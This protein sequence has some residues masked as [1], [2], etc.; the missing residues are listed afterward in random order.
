MGARRL[1][2]AGLVVLACAAVA[3]TALAAPA[4][5]GRH[6]QYFSLMNERVAVKKL[7]FGMRLLFR[8]FPGAKS[9]DSPRHGHGPV[10]FGEVERPG[11]TIFGAGRGHWICVGHEWNAE[12]GGG[13][14]SCTTRAG[15][16]ELGLLD[17]GSCGK[18]RPRHFRVNGLVPDGVTALELERSDATIGRTVPVIDNTFAFTVGREDFTLHGV[19][20]A[21]AEGLER[22][23]PLAHAG[24]FGDTRGGCAFYTFAEAKSGDEPPG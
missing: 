20:D 4:S 13:G 3:G 17:V 14:G 1:I 16:R 9:S 18:G 10:W 7:P 11:S 22:T 15:A 23:L 12:V 2:A 24:G 5:G 6:L 8:D 19:G 21:F